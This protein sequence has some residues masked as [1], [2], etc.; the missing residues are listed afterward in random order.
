MALTVT[1][2]SELARTVRSL[3]DELCEGRVPA[4]LEGGYDLDALAASV[5]ATIAM[6][7]A[8]QSVLSSASNEVIEIA[9]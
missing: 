3:A 5:L 1:A 9:R 6:L 8:D 7:G 2:S 4:I